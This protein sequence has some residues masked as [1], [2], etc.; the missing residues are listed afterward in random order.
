MRSRPLLHD[1]RMRS[2][3]V[4]QE[5][6]RAADEARS[7]QQ[8]LVDAEEASRKLKQ[9]LQEEADRA[10]TAQLK[11][12]ETQREMEAQIRE[13]QELA[14]KVRQNADLCCCAVLLIMV[15]VLPDN[16]PLVWLLYWC[17]QLHRHA[18]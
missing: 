3:Q 12:A 2:V 4:S 9:E 11:V 17:D 7:A 6:K 10:A 18:Y 13:Q 15:C 5:A 14:R 8:A 16:A 1:P